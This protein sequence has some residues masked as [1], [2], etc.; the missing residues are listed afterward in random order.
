M[1]RY[2]LDTDICSY[3]MKRSNDVLLK[4]LQRITVGDVCVSVITKS[5][6]L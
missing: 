3:L 5:E 6:L 2:M 4:R 1:L